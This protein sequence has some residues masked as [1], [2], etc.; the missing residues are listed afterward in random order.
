MQ[1][2]ALTALIND[3]RKEFS[4]FTVQDQMRIIALRA[5]YE[6][7]ASVFE[8]EIAKTNRSLGRESDTVLQS[9]EQ[10]SDAAGVPL[11]GPI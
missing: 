9:A 5:W 10:Q 4:E 6:G 11:Q 7:R 2:D 1:T 8:A 3:V